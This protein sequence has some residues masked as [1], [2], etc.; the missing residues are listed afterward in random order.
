RAARVAPRGVARGAARRGPQGREGEREV[1]RA[2]EGRHA[3]HRAE[4]DDHV[5]NTARV[6]PVELVYETIGDPADPPL[7][8]V[9]GL[10]TQLIH[11]ETEFCE[12]L[13]ARGFRVI[14]FDNR[15]PVPATQTAAPPPN[16][17]RAGSGLKVDAPYLLDDMASDTFGLL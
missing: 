11:W 9:M 15:E 8:L 1:E 12:L 3:G 10:G 17:L 2:Q 4:E 16:M 7:L 14:R 6:G 13:A 5:V